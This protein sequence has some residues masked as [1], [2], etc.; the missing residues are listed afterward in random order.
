MQSRAHWSSGLAP[1]PVPV[2]SPRE[3]D[4]ILAAME[5][6]VKPA[7]RLGVLV[8]ALREA[9]CAC[10]QVAADRCGVW[11]CDASSPRE[12]WLELT[13]FLRAWELEQGQAVVVRLSA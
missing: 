6:L 8:D 7:E 2:F 3:A 9:G 13:F 11:H 1:L 4:F 12:A 5:V 10:V